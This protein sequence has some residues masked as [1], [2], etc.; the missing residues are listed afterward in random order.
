M[1]ERVS[2]TLMSCVTTPVIVYDMNK[3]ESIGKP[4]SPDK[5]GE[6]PTDD[7]VVHIPLISRH[8]CTDWDE[9]EQGDADGDECEQTRSGL[10][11]LVGG[12]GP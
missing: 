6:L 1:R 3:P 9:Y 5:Q 7:R 11:P 12:R 10:R 8:K 4:A 2:R